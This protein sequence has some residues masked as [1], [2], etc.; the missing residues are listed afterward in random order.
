MM[1]RLALWIGAFAGMGLLSG[2]PP[3]RADDARISEEQITK[4]VKKSIDWIYQQQNPWGT[5]EAAQEPAGT[6]RDLA[7]Q[8]Q[9]GFRTALALRC[10][11]T[12]GENARDPRIQKAVDFLITDEHIAG[13]YAVGMRAQ[14]WP[15]LGHDPA[16]R[17]MMV[18]DL[19]TLIAA[20][21]PTGRTRG[22]YSFRTDFEN[23][24][25]YADHSVSFYGTLGVKALADAGLEV[26]SDYWTTVERA[27]RSQQGRDGS[28]VFEIGSTARQERTMGM[29]AS[30]VAVLFAADD[31][32]A[33]LRP[34]DCTGT[35]PDHNVETGL[36]WIDAH[37]DQSREAHEIGGFSLRNYALYAI[38][39]IGMISGRKY[40][41]QR[42]WYQDG[43]KML[44]ASQKAA[45]GS[46]DNLPDTC[47]ATL[48][49]TRGRNPVLVSKLQYDVQS[50]PTRRGQPARPPTGPPR[51]GA[52][53]LRPRDM[54]NLT[55]WI[56]VQV[57][58]EFNWQTVS[59]QVPVEELHDS[60]VLFIS[61]NRPLNLMPADKAKLKLF[62]QEGGI[63]LGNAD[64]GNAD[65]AASFRR[66][67]Q[68]LFPAYEF[69]AVPHDSVIYTGEEFRAAKWKEPPLVMELNNGVRDLMLLIPQADPSRYFQ[70]HQVGSFQYAYE[71]MA[72]ILFYSVD[73]NGMLLKGETYLVRPDPNAKINRTVKI[74]RLQY[75]GNWDPEPGGWIRLAADMRNTR[76]IDLQ[77]TPIALG[78]GK[79]D[80]SF[81]IAH[82]TGTAN[83]H[84]SES[85]CSEL[86]NFIQQGGTLVIDAA[87]GSALF[88]AAAQSQIKAILPDGGLE[89]LASDHPV[90]RAGKLLTHAAFRRYERSRLPRTD[91]FRLQGVDVAG[92]ARTGLF[93][94]A[95]D[96]TEGLVGEPIDGIYGYQ[97]QTA[98]DLMANLIVYGSQK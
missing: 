56:G 42:D 82:L 50:G 68:E 32:L 21:H 88:D 69:R 47:F 3:A 6:Q 9:F 98:T 13:V 16:V 71:L 81:K 60:A 66:L 36:A 43:A 63:L 64:C 19:R 5:W 92:G 30:G 34:A 62:V 55:Q 28:W 67:G 65:F 23:E 15:L 53:D 74:A 18:R 33:A 76:G 17:Q 58:Q 77:V 61:G 38:A 97:P 93:Y 44:L 85:A 39:R 27:W 94:S 96:L 24:P 72:D 22:L 89:L 57:E 80:S 41:G 73:Q 20:V 51:L 70:Q 75:P 31:E 14:V 7:D 49:L 84:L 37:F 2:L 8:G 26:P 40:F 48:F 91:E 95:E 90:Y 59:L 45:D 78:E 79:L 4:S 46:W 35:P 11:L 29:T 87:G 12:A 52:W 83:F 86:R 10:L 1:V 54:A 25:E